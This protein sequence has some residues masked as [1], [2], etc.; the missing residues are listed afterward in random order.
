MGE[1]SAKSR[2]TG[3]DNGDADFD[4]RPE[5]WNRIVVGCV[6]RLG[7]LG[8]V[9]ETD[10]AGDASSKIVWSVMFKLIYR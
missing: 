3:A 4:N 8:K 5:N 2:E 10:H 9:F 1:E 7:K 6:C